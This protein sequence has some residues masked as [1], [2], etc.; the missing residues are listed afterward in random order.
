MN[1]L[2]F[3]IPTMEQIKES[4]ALDR[5]GVHAKIS[6]FAL[7]NGC[8]IYVNDKTGIYYTNDCCVNKG[9]KAVNYNRFSDFGY[10]SYFSRNY[11][12][13]EIFVGK[14]SR[15]IGCRITVPYSQIKNACTNKQ[16]LDGNILEVEFGEFWL[17]VAPSVICDKLDELYK[18]GRYALVETNRQCTTDSIML[19]GYLS[20]FYPK[21]N[22]EYYYNG[23]YYLRLK[24]KTDYDQFTRTSSPITLLAKGD[25]KYGVLSR[26]YKLGDIVWLERVPIK[27]LVDI[28]LDFAITKDIIIGGIRYDDICRYIN[29]FF[30]K[31]I[32]IPNRNKLF[33]EESSL[34]NSD[35]NTVLSYKE[36]DI[37]LMISNG[38]N[39]DEIFQKYPEYKNAIL[40]GY[41]NYWLSKH[42]EIEID[43]KFNRQYKKIRTHN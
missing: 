43:K 29:E 42:P 9:V 40:D 10:D 5:Y 1:N 25:N 24:V 21:Y 7:V 16:F 35:V 19:E 3:S 13:Y 28:D 39:P 11:E 4:K 30:S 23:K 22:Y 6:D 2:K 27:W 31:E 36:Q 14:S 38:E 33:L 15:K 8:K 41:Y 18:S 17:N 32:V 12:D 37:L 20:E 34:G 26:T